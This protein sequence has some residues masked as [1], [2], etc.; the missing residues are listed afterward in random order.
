MLLKKE[1]GKLFLYCGCFISSFCGSLNP[2]V[3]LLFFKILISSSF[4]SS[5]ETCFSINHKRR[6]RI[7]NYSAWNFTSSSFLWYTVLVWRRI[8][9]LNL[10]INSTHFLI[11]SWIFILQFSLT[12]NN[13]I[14]RAIGP[15]LRKLTKSNQWFNILG[16]QNSKFLLAVL[17]LSIY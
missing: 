3:C 14:N 17:S 12:L 15:I 6:I 8:I 7:T 16:N 10:L 13:E 4:W 2:D 1:G 11:I 5:A 9:I